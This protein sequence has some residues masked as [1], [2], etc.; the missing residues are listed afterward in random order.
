MKR[1]LCLLLIFSLPVT[2]LADTIAER[3]NAP[4]HWQGEFQSNT[5]RTHIYVAMTVEVPEADAFPIYAVEPHAFTMEETTHAANVLL[6]EGNWRQMDWTDA[7]VEDGPR[8]LASEYAGD[9]GISYDC[10]LED[11]NHRSLLTHYAILK[12]LP[13]WYPS[14]FLSYS[15]GELQFGR[16]I[17]T[18]EEAIALADRLIAQIAPGMHLESID[19]EKD[20][21]YMSGRTGNSAGDDYGYRLYYARE[22]NGIRITPVY[23]QGAEAAGEVFNPVLPYEHLWIDVGEKGIFGVW[24]EYPIEVTDR[25]AEDCELLPF[26]TILD[27]FGTIAPLTIQRYEY[28]ANNNLYIDR[29][30]LGYMCLQERGKPDHYQLVPVWDFFGERTIGPERYDLHNWAYLTVNAID[31]T[32]IDRNYGY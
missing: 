25:L 3:V 11:G 14:N 20:G 2:A 15:L 10:F 29:A 18:E 5:G 30:V 22:V 32:V 13:D 26:E 9:L 6:G 19:P 31:G 16:N 8:Y 23:Q 24:W 7:V 21:K 17:G 27:I 28:E 1:L 12:A 4:E